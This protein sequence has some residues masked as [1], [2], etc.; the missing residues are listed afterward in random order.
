MEP[1]FRW[2]G[3][4]F[5]LFL[6]LRV[7]LARRGKSFG[8]GLG[9]TALN[10]VTGGL[11]GLVLSAWAGV[12]V[13]HGAGDAALGPAAG[14]P[15]VAAMVSILPFVAAILGGLGGYLV[16]GALWQRLSGT[17]GAA[18]LAR[19]RRVQIGLCGVLV[20]AWILIRVNV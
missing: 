17:R 12:R 5:V 15:F 14:D 1:L 11:A 10:L 8:L 4:L 13:G 9:P 20:I 3:I 7:S 6:V 2:V 18:P 16:L 19:L